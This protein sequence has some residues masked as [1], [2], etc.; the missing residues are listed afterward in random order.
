MV[1][2]MTPVAH[3]AGTRAE[4]E[5]LDAAVRLSGFTRSGLPVSLASIAPRGTSRGVEAWTTTD[6]T[7]RRIF[8]YTGSRQCLLKVASIV[9]HEASHLLYGATEAEAYAAQIAFLT[10]HG[11]SAV[12]IAGVRRARAYVLASESNSR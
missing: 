4:R 12:S 5:T 8:I 6:G 7:G 9:V 3:H 11:A 2:G 10:L 1:L